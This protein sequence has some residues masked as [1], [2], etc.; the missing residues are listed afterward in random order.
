DAGSGVASAEFQHRPAGGGPWTTID[1][2]TTTPYSVNWDTTP[3]ADG[4]HAVRVITTDEAGNTL[5][6]AS[7]TVTVDNTA[8]SA[9]VVTLSESSPF[10]HV[11]GTEIFVNTDEAGSYEVEAVTSDPDSGIDKVRFP[12]PTDDFSSPYSATY[13]FGDLSG[14]QTITAFNGAGLTASTPF[15]VTPDTVEPT[16]GSVDY[17]DGYDADG[18]V[19]VGVDAGT[20]A[21]SGIAPASAV[22]ERRTAALSDGSCD[23][24]AGGWSLVTSPDTV[25]SGLCAEYRY[26]VSDRVGNEAT[27]TS[28]NIVKVDLVSPGA[29][30]LTLVESSPY[31]HVVGAEIFVNTN[32]AGSYDVEAST[33]DAVSGI[34]KVVFPGGI[35]DTSAPYASTYDFDDLLGTE[36]VTAHDGA[37]NTASSDFDITEDISA[38]STTDDTASI[39][40]GW[41]TAPVTV[42]LTPTDA[43]SGVVAT[44]YTTDGSV[45]TTSS[46]EGTSFDLTADGVYVIRYFSVDNVGNV[47]P[48]RTAS[49]TIRID[50][51]N[52]SQPAI[53]LDESSPYA[54]VSG[55]EI[56]VNPNQTG[57]YGVSATTSDA[58]SGI[59]RVAFP[60]G[61]DDDTSPY[62]ATF[63]LDDLSGAQTVTAHDVAGNTASDTF[64][65]TPDTTAPAGGSVDYPDGYDADGDVTVT[66]DAGTDALSGLAPGSAVLERQTAALAGGLCDPFAA[67]W[68]AVTSPDTVPDSTCA[69]YRYRV[70]DRVGNEAT[71]TSANVVKVDL[72]APQTTIDVAPGDPSSDPS[73]AFEF[74]ASEAGS[75]FECRLDGGAWSACSSPETVGPLADGSHTFQVRA[76]D[77]AGL[78]DPTPASH[79]W[80]VDTVAP[81]TTFDNV[82]PDPS[83]DDAPTFEFSADEAGSTFE[84]RLDGGAWTACPSPETIGLLTDGSHTFEVRAVDGAGNLDPSPASYTWTVDTV[85]P[86]SSFSV[87]PGDPTNDTTPTFEF[88]ADEGG[89]AFECRLDGGAWSACSS[90]ETRGPLAD[91][92]HTF[93]VRATDPAGNQETTPESYTW[94]VDTG[95]PPVT[96]TQPSGFVNAADADPYT[97]R[98]TSP[99]GDVA[100]VEFFRCSDASAAC[101]TGSWVSL[102]TDTTAPYEA[103]W[104]LDPDGNRALR[105]VATDTASDTGA[106]VVDVTIDRTVPA[107]AIDSAPS[108][109][110]GSSSASFEFSASESGVTFECRLDAGAWGGCSSPHGYAGLTEGGH[111][112]HVRA[113]DAAANVDPTPATFS[114]AVD[115]VG[116]ETTIDIA[117]AD[118]SGSPAPSFEFSSSE[119]GSTFECRLDGGAWSAC[120]GPH[121]YT[122]LADGSHTFQVRATDAAGN[123]DPTPATHVWTIDATPPGGGLADPGQFL[124]GTVALS[125][126]PSD[127]GAGVQSVDFQVSP[128][129]AGS[130]TSIGVDT[131]DP[132]GT[133]W[134]TTAMADGAYDLRIVVTDNAG[135]S[136]PS[137]VVEDRVVDNTAPGATMNDPGAHLRGTVSLTA[138]ASDAGSGVDAVSFERS[139][140]GAGDWTAVATSWD[141]T[142]VA[143]GLYD[144]RVTVTD[145]A[146]NST[147]SASVTDRRVDNTKPSLTA[148]TPA[149]GV[150]IASASSLEVVASEDMAGIVGAE[151][152][153]APAPSPSVSGDTVTYQHSFSPGPHLLAGE[154]ED[155]AGNRQPIRIHFTTW[156]GATADYPYVEKNSYS[157]SSMSLR[158]ASDT[159]TVTVPAGAWTGAPTGDWLVV[160]IDPQPG[161]GGSGGFQPASE[162]LDVTAYWAL[163]G[164]AVTSFSLPIEIVV[165]NDQPHV[166]PA[167]FEGGAWRPL[168]EAPGS[169]LPAAWTD[170]FASEGTNV[171]ILTRHLSLFTLLED[172]E[173]P[174]KPGAFKGTVRKG[175][176]SLTWTAATDNS[177]LI[178]AYRV[179]AN[180][181]L[182]KTVDGSKRSVGMG[183]FRLTD[184]RAFQV[185]AED[186]AGN[187]GP[188]TVA[189]KVVPKLARLSLAAA[190]AA[191][192]KRGFKTGKITWMTSA[193]V[194]AGRVV[195]GAV[196]GLRPAGSKV[197]LRVSRGPAAGRSFAPAPPPPSSPTA[198][199]PAS[200]PPPPAPAATTPTPS[201]TTPTESLGEP[202]EPRRGRVFPFPTRSVDGFSEVRRELGFGLLAAAFSIALIAGL[203]ARRPAPAA[204]AAQGDQLLLWDQRIVRAIRRFLR[205]S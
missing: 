134:D 106:D 60:G 115:T 180:G 4:N 190:K 72:T 144:L 119:G 166:V 118:P 146:G 129:D 204:P 91:G 168:A 38:P 1:T 105:A 56:F 42:T 131:T 187:V 78:T 184:R 89:S 145:N 34:A 27:Y 32:E 203:R 53:A 13:G 140:A 177:G 49:A 181:T 124:R 161:T 39:G 143:D 102:G 116:P 163:D 176:F 41:Q 21:L 51:T 133:G 138:D 186:G 95:A 66:V 121:S 182:V 47:E 117:P 114:W 157:A 125:G 69:R 85:A 62:S 70:S 104:P 24:F 98:A 11:S 141:T 199:P 28:A 183:A 44:Y 196:G 74:S 67:G 151:I 59:D 33:S 81:D 123:V 92:S 164:S 139:P 167:V 68:T 96:I 97:V 9:P 192:K 205:L 35:E 71:Y 75:T 94:T 15:T 12:G 7:R 137:A 109:P 99:D 175:K 82:P 179:Y 197:G 3:L 160:R 2:D 188:Q 174:T 136:S 18:D 149:D 45:P 107:T 128:A 101:S 37:G 162:N 50:Q 148:S 200:S 65:A 46:D 153:G 193:T 26:R 61:I 147:V 111:S 17:P 126:S 171:R 170:G 73:P 23:P 20:D 54:H 63:D 122:G 52:P 202:D 158:S 178:S 84:C 48:V 103:S 108:D 172:V 25:G 156:T 86:D 55:S 130:W 31:A 76:T 79:A 154:L 16:G 155:L 120:A 132:Y 90:P 30:L 113:T 14:P 135:N 40:S 64:T 198:T 100:D 88:S 36:T 142:G 77:T 80:T 127:D 19:T 112:F 6:S 165:D 150:T 57:S 194:P 110:S 152:D 185:A 43:R 58:G 189:L 5:T 195:K 173:P 169:G 87:V 10:A 22:L 8:P 93:Q 191:L 29:P 159:T 201:T 83:N